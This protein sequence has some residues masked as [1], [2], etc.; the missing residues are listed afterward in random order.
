MIQRSKS[1]V[2]L[3]RRGADANRIKSG[4]NLLVEMPTLNASTGMAQGERKGQWI[5]LTSH[6]LGSI[7]GESISPLSTFFYISVQFVHRLLPP[8]LFL[9]NPSFDRFLLVWI[10]LF[11]RFTYYHSKLLYCVFYYSLHQVYYSLYHQWTLLLIL[12]FLYDLSIVHIFSIYLLSDMLCRSFFCLTGRLIKI[13]ILY[14]LRN[15]IPITSSTV[16][17]VFVFHN[18][19]QSFDLYVP[20]HMTLPYHPRLFSLSASLASLLSPLSP[21]HSYGGCARPHHG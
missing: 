2:N 11:E 5:D 19:F 16:I 14:L 17:L 13:Y 20:H 10:W 1:G 15:Y 7:I 6:F 12:S 18:N 3:L 4:M 9:Y 21:V 8:F